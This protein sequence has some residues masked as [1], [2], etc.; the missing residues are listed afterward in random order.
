MGNDT[1]SSGDG[2]E[3]ARHEVAAWV[4]AQRVPPITKLVLLLVFDR[5]GEL[6][7]GRWA[8]WPKLAT[9]AHEAGLGSVATV[10]KHLAALESLGLIEREA[11]YGHAGR[12]TTNRIVLLVQ[13]APTGA[14]TPPQGTPPGAG[15]GAPTGAGHSVEAPG[16]APGVER[17]SARASNGDDPRNRLPDDFPEHLKPHA[18]AVY[19]ILR[20]IA[21]QHPTAGVVWPLS[22][23]KAIATHPRHPL[24]GVAHELDGWA[25]DPP[26]PIRDVVATYRTFL[27]R[28]RELAAA[29]ALADDGTP[30]NAPRGAPAGVHPIRGGRYD[31]ATRAK[32]AAALARL[33]ERMGV[34]Q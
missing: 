13:G 12:Q 22:V 23:G 25:V 3:I 6:E 14:G 30:T 24:V 28:R 31:E 9:L 32:D 16:E 21:E 10:R 15:Q 26:R 11:R 33:S 4:R 8:A 27:D 1:R 34:G 7:D 5:A 19:R 20:A 2:H 29:E 17:G 18:R